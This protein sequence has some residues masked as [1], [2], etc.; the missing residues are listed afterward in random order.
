[1]KILAIVLLLI[2]ITSF[3]QSNKQ[4]S[5]TTTKIKG[6]KGWYTYN[7]GEAEISG[8][9]NY[10][11]D[12]LVEGKNKIEN[13][14]SDIQ[15]S[16]NITAKAIFGKDYL[17]KVKFNYSLPPTFYREWNKSALTICTIINLDKSDMTTSQKEKINDILVK[18]F[19]SQVPDNSDDSKKK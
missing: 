14:S 15:K 1:M 5:L 8:S 9:N 6:C 19:D 10:N 11:L 7:L 18:L 17:N 16:G 4:K 13:A 2:S 3:G 12:L